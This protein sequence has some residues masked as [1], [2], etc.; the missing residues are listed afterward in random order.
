MPYHSLALLD[1]NLVAKNNLDTVRFRR[2]MTARSTHKWKVGG[3]S[4]RGLDQKLVPPAVKR[5][6]ALGIVD[7]VDQHAAVGA[8]VKGNPQ[9]L[10]SLLA[11]GIPELSRM[12]QS[13]ESSTVVVREGRGGLKPTCMVTCLSSTMTSRVR[14]SAPM[15]AL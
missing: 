10:K 14:K 3:I 11:G 9:R 5:L 7:I 4:G 6:E 15:V 13:G 1:I 2:P 8:A 12:H